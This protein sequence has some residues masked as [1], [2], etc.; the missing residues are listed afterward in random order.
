MNLSEADGGE[1]ATGIASQPAQQKK[2]SKRTKLPGTNKRKQPE[3]LDPNDVLQERIGRHSR[4]KRAVHIA[5][6]TKAHNKAV[7]EAM[8][9]Q[10]DSSG[11]NKRKYALTEIKADIANKRLYVRRSPPPYGGRHLNPT[12][13]HG[14]EPPP[15]P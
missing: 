13:P 3:E 7:A 1:A 12:L 9:L 2:N 6:R 8:E 4:S 11:G 14:R 10:I 5:A 15:S